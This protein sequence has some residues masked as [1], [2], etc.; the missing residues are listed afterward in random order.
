MRNAKSGPTIN[1]RLK[2]LVIRA[3]TG[4]DAFMCGKNCA[5][6]WQSGKNFPLMLRERSEGLRGFQV[7]IGSKKKPRSDERGFNYAN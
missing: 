5:D 6:R 2:R 3:S 1:F 7:V 4:R